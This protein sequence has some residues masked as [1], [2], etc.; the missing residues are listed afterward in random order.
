MRRIP[1]LLSRVAIAAA[2]ALAAAPTAMAVQ[3]PDAWITTKVKIKLLTTEGM[4]STGVNVDTIDGLVTLHGRVGT[5]AEKAKAAELAH[6]ID[7]V[8]DVR[9]LIQVSPAHEKKSAA[10]ADAALEKNVSAKLKA[11]PA[12][13]DSSVQVES[14]K[15]GVV[16]LG[17]KAATLSDHYRAIDDASRVDGVRR[18]ASEIQSPDTMADEEL[19]HDS[20]AKGGTQGD[21][22]SAKQKA[23]DMWITSA[24]KMRLIA[25]SDTPAFDI[26]VDTHDGSVTLFGMVDSATTKQK[27]ESEVRKVDGVRNVVNDLQ[28]VSETRKD[29]VVHSDDTLTKEI[30]SRLGKRSA[31]ADS[32]VK[33]EV[34]NGVARL[35][36][37]VD[38]WSEHLTALSLA[39]ATTGVKKVIDD[40]EV[41]P[42]VS[43]GAG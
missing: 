36:G 24:A 19:W 40:L 16:L 33:V 4:A 12:L 11:D 20:K 43:A 34:S 30:Q 6:Q 21:M 31:L 9:N 15:D 2:L 41:R 10:V 38:S 22:A 7:G 28:V 29:A 32:D 5:E 39:R 23:T 25:S 35:S 14:V 17:G 27:A 26:N 18:V 8:R 3:Q 42:K 37:H 13:G 1:A